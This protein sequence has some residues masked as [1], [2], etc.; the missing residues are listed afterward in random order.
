MR[1]CREAADREALEALKDADY[2]T[3]TSSSTVRNFLEARRRRSPT[4]FARRLDRPGDQRDRGASRA[5]VHV[6]AERHD[7]DGLVDA[8]VADATRFRIGAVARPISFLSDYGYD[9]E[10]AGVCRGVIARIAP[11]A[12]IIDITHGIPRATTSAPGRWR[13]RTRCPSCPPGVHLAVVDPGVGGER[14][15][16]A[17]RAPATERIL[18][19]PDNGLLAPG[20]RAARR[21][22][23]G[24]RHR[25]SPPGW[26]RS[27]RPSMAAI[28]SPRSRRGSRSATRSRRLGEPI[29]AAR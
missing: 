25:R 22:G 10:F 9:D 2:V 17:L 20:A 24:G 7:I 19:G 11:E 3:F 5:R 14:R 28:S 18:V 15:P 4:D 27:R 26:S 21:R 13:W 29:D 1:P 12:R 23:R 16:V 8:L 6:E